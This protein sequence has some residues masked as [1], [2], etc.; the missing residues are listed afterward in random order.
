MDAGFRVLSTLIAGVLIYG[1]LGWLG[2]HALHTR[3]LVAIGIV[4]GAGLGVYTSIRRLLI[5]SADD[6][7][8]GAR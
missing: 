8:K 2:D 1:G 5:Q 3:F 6:V 4:L 7:R